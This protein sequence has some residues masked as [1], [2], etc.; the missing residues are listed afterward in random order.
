MFDECGKAFVHRCE[1]VIQIS[2]GLRGQID[3]AVL[4]NTALESSAGMFR[5]TSAVIAPRTLFY[6]SAGDMVNAKEM[7]LTMTSDAAV[8]SRCL[9]PIDGGSVDPQQ[10]LEFLISILQLRTRLALVE[11]L[12]DDGVIEQ[13]SED[14]HEPV[15]TEDDVTKLQ[16]HALRAALK[17]RGLPTTGKK[18]ELRG[19]LLLRLQEEEKNEEAV[20]VEAQQTPLRK[21]HL[22][23]LRGVVSTVTQ[24][25]SKFV[26]D[27]EHVLPASMPATNSVVE[28]M[29][30]LAALAEVG[31]DLEYCLVSADRELLLQWAEKFRRE[32]QTAVK[33][34]KVVPC[35]PTAT[36]VQPGLTS[37]M[38]EEA[39][40]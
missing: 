25:A 2:T 18:A 38:G 12:C 22:S 23:L 36:P 16:V 26:H 13:V 39:S 20:A 7:A 10:P 8:V 30:G 19:R 14:I 29:A 32:V 21:Q 9:R 27:V 3:G 35:K 24:L 40:L 4:L 31:A 17:A 5:Q 28:L 37:P 33:L 15:L 6:G 11:L 34:V 1:L